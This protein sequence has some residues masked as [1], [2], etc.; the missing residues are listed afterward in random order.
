[1]LSALIPSRHSYP[2]LQL[3]PKPAHQRSVQPDP[4]V[5]GPTP[6]LRLTPAADRDQPVSRFL[7]ADV[8]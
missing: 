7:D 5:L 6:L 8:R 1:M 3:V 2:A 4:L